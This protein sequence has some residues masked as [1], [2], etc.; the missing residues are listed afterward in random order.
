MFV[1]AA[2]VPIT[3]MFPDLG[4]P[5][6][7][8]NLVNY[9]EMN[10]QERNTAQHL[11]PTLFLE[12]PEM[13][14]YL[15]ISFAADLVSFL[16]YVIGWI[17]L[18]R[19]KKLH[20]KN[21]M[22]L[23]QWISLMGSP[24]IIFLGLCRLW[25][26]QLFIEVLSYKHI[27]IAAFIYLIHFFLSFAYIQCYITGNSPKWSITLMEQH[28]P[29]GTALERVLKVLKPVSANMQLISLAIETVVFSLSFMM[30]VGNSLYVYVSDMVF[31]A[32]NLFLFLTLIWYCITE[33]FLQK[34]LRVQL[35]YYIG[36]IVASV[37]LYLPV[38]RYDD[39]FVS[40]KLHTAVTINIFVIPGL[41]VLAFFVRIIR[42]FCYYAGKKP[43]YAPLE[44]QEMKAAATT[45]PSRKTRRGRQ[46]PEDSIFMEAESSGDETIF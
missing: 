17:A 46:R 34:Y 21:L 35:G 30:A 28:I 20:I 14:T 3:A 6:S 7:Y 2:V 27:F 32:I 33:F 36:V 31:G 40:A 9:S 39:V 29:A 1:M 13:F 19:A 23:S 15:T 11:T 16:Y 4:Y 42:A 37:I 10:L 24:T 5:C 43:E 22:T 8:I 12:G 18:L 45:R 41:A 26:I 38:Y 44:L 25:T